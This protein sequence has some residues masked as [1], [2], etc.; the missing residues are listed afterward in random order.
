MEITRHGGEVVIREDLNL[1]DEGVSLSFGEGESTG[2]PAPMLYWLL[3]RGLQAIVRREGRFLD[4]HPRH[5]VFTQRVTL[6]CRVAT[7]R[8]EPLQL[9]RS[10]QNGRDARVGR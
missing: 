7:R 10:H 8:G 9:C 5:D 4:T 2:Y 3:D 1:I 6:F